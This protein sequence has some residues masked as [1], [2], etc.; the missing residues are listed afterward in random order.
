[1]G[2]GDG[3]G[4]AHRTRPPR[5]GGWVEEGAGARVFRFYNRSLDYVRD[6][7]TPRVWMSFCQGID[8]PVFRV[9]ACVSFF[10]SF[11]F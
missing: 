9:S 5:S 11:L 6:D 10:F 8:R 4:I 1:M 7:I 2:V 3:S